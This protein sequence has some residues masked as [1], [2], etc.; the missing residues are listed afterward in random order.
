MLALTAAPLL[1]SPFQKGARA[2]ERRDGRPDVDF[3]RGKEAAVS[4]G[5]KARFIG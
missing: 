4:D 5:A 1:C 3:K 2:S